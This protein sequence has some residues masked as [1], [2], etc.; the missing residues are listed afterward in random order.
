MLLELTEIIK[1]EKGRIDWDEY[2]M[3]IALLGSCRSPCS[4]LHVGCVIVKDNRIISMGY[5]GFIAGCKHTSHIRD[6]HEQATV[7]SEINAITDCAKRGVS[8][9]GAKIFITHYPCINCFK[10]I[11]SCGIN[12]I[13]YLNDY[14]NDSLVNELILEADSTIKIRKYS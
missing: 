7:H 6:G 4:R 10:A 1:N 9:D 8:V 12:E 2:F 11:K 13:I 14:N 3:S 5:N